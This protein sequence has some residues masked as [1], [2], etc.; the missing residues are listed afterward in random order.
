MPIAQSLFPSRSRSHGSFPQVRRAAPTG[1]NSRASRT[2]R[3]YAA[4]SGRSPQPCHV[5]S[6]SP[7]SETICGSLTAYLQNGSTKAPEPARASC[8][9]SPNGLPRQVVEVL[10][11]LATELDRGR[12]AESAPHNLA[13]WSPHPSRRD[14]AWRECECAQTAGIELAS[15]KGFLI[16]IRP[17]LLSNPQDWTVEGIG[18]EIRPQRS[19]MKAPAHD[20]NAARPPDVFARMRIAALCAVIPA[21]GYRRSFLSR[22]ID[23]TELKPSLY[24]LLDELLAALDLPPPKAPAI[25]NPPQRGCTRAGRP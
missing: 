13:Y 5:P 8:S 7:G 21:G 11:D 24:N 1:Q 25:N 2:R 14:R 23:H 12:P 10:L 15:E 22:R 6:L 18:G 17:V 19:R 20:P 16:V 9:T 3:R 4:C